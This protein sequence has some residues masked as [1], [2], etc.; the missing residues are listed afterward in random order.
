MD[1]QIT[2]QSHHGG[3]GRLRSRKLSSV[4]K[5]QRIHCHQARQLRRTRESISGP[6]PLAREVM[7][8]LPKIGDIGQVM[9]LVGGPR[10]QQYVQGVAERLVVH[11]DRELPPLE[12]EAKVENGG[13]DCQGAALCPR[14]KPDGPETSTPPYQKLT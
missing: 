14:L 2:C 5:H 7:Y 4:K 10:S 12:H 13:V 1:P 6:I 3:A 11:E 9:L 8:I